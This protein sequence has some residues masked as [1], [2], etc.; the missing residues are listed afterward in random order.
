MFSANSTADTFFENCK[1]WKAEMQQLRLFMNEA[2][3]EEELKWGVPCYTFNKKNIVIIHGFKEYCAINFFK[4][5]LLTDINKLLIQQT[6]NSQSTRQLRFTTVAQILKLQ[7]IIKAYIQEAIAIE[8][9]GLK[10]ILKK[11]DEYE[12]PL[13]LQN[14]FKTKQGEK[15]KKAFYTLTP[16]RQRGY[17]LHFASA[18]QAQTRIERIE[19]YTQQIINGKGLNDCTC[20]LSQ[21]MPACDGSHKQLKK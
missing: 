11:Q 14:I 13:E 10:V 15:L 4:G 20:G 6:E 19:K 2:I 3:L 18:K 1:N 12:M 5:A 17:L 21:K 9:A 8:E 7:P 16:G